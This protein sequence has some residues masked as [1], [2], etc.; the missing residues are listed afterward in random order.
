MDTART[1]QSLELT[2]N[3]LEA[4]VIAV[5]EPRLNL[6]RGRW[7]EATQYYQWFESD[8]EEWEEDDA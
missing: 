1:S 6:Q 8:E 7:G 5:S 4:V 2:L 3:I